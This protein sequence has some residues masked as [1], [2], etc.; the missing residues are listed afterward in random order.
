VD[1]RAAI[2]SPE[3]TRLRQMFAELEPDELKPFR[4]DVT[5]FEIY[6]HGTGVAAVA[7]DGN[8]FIRLLNARGT[9]DHRS[10]RAC[11]TIESA[12]AEAAAMRAK[13]EYFKQH[14]VRVVN[15]SW[16]QNRSMIETDLERHGAG[17]TVEQRAQLARTIFR[18]HRDALHHAIEGAPAILFVCGS[19]NFGNDVQFDEM[20]PGSFK[21]P[22]LLVV[23]AVD[24]Y[25]VPTSFTG[26]GDATR[27]YANGYEVS[28]C[29]PGGG[30][31]A[32]SGVSIAI[33]GATNLAAKL[34]ALEPT[35]TPPQ[36]IEL[37]ERGAKRIEG[38]RLVRIVDPLKTVA[39]LAHEQGTR[40]D[41]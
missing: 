23:G 3:A 7:A 20:I 33:P 5:L 36:V 16:G 27:V 40:K 22:N 6:A 9:F 41:G 15:M 32:M 13:V 14:G 31:L 12:K 37:I 38:E 26:T 28:T 25:G 11:P 1:I 8:P 17:A 2:D 29:I 39:L 21:L 35:L 19:T 30:R 34:L 18:I 10:P 4:E 24:K